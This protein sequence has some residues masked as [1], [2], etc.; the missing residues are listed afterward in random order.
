MA[1]QG[2]NTSKEDALRLC[3]DLP[4]SWRLPRAAMVVVV[5]VVSA[6]LTPLR[7]RIAMSAGVS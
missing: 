7:T 3:P 4:R 5:P 2:H 1:V 6:H